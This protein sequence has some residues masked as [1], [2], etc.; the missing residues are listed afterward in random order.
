MFMK[1]RAEYHPS[2]KITS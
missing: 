2:W 1:R